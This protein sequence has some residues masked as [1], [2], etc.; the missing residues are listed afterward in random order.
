M[1]FKDYYATLGVE[2][3]AGADEI[4]RAYR[5]LA[6][7]YHP[8]VSKEPDAEAKFKE[9]T[10]AHEVL[11]DAEKRAAYDQVGTRWQGGAPPPD[12][13]SGFEFSGREGGAPA[14]DG[15]DYSE[16]FESLF[17]R[18]AGAASHGRA[19][20]GSDH[21][22]KVLIDLR[23]AYLGATRSISLRLPVFDAQGHPS[24]QERQLDVGIPRGIRPGQQLR[25][26]GQGGGGLG[27][28]PA[29]DLYLEIDFKPDPRFR[30]EGRDVVADLP[31]A[32]WEAALGA[33]LT[34]TT[35]DREVELRVP[36]GSPAG[37]RMRLKG[38]GLPGSPTGDFYAALV[39]VLPP[40]DGE[41]AQQAWR[42]LAG[43]FDGFNPRAAA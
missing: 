7:K 27:G 12:W 40:S 18:R 8:D 39:I 14:G 28:G 11:R 4:K 38:L 41:A 13:N 22:A 5:K 29:G 36:P 17:G 42:T 16:F 32:P 31:L 19:R 25:L 26:A 9:L 33:T 30:V 37:R 20:A 34:V 10:E 3:S 35:P 21:H 6:R 23:D 2:R 43:A 24:W 1:E 15:A